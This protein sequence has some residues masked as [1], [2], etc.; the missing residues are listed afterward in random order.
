MELE[1][2]DEDE[3]YEMQFGNYFENIKAK[4][5]NPFDI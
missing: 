2:Q 1:P 5:G 3:V 4:T